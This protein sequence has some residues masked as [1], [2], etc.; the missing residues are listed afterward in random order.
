[1]EACL[2]AA[3][4]SKANE[5]AKA[6]EQYTF[7]LNGAGLSDQERAGVLVDRGNSY[8]KTGQT[9]RA[10]TDFSQ[11]IQLNPS[12]SVA[13][14]NRGNALKT[15]GRYDE[16]LTD[17]SRA[18]ALAP[19]NT[20]IYN[21]RANTYKAMGKY[22]QAVVELD[23]AVELQPSNAIT[24]YNRACLESVRKNT[25]AACEWLGKA[26]DKG[27]FEKEL[28]QADRDLDNIRGAACYEKLLRRK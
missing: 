13:Y 9:D 23:K 16:A 15:K 20:M 5:H 1:V 17:F 7:C 25:T 26:I 11:A 21:N 12:S 24:Y 28:I 6:I 27:F 22:D 19:M 4:F 10:I 18:L 2:R 14:N 3:E 8:N